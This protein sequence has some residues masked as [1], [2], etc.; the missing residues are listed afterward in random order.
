MNINEAT[1]TDLKVIEELKRLGWKPGDTLLYQPEYTLTPEQ[2]K[3]FGVKKIRPDIVLC[4][5]QGNP[6]AVIENKL[7]DEKKALTKLRTLYYHVL[8]PRFLYACSKERI[9]FSDTTWKGL[10]SGTFKRVQTFMTLDEMLIKIE[11]DKRKKLTEKIEID[12]TI[13]GGYDPAAGK[14]RYYQL[15]CVNTLIEKYKQ[16]KQKMLVHMATGLGKTRVAVALTKALLEYGLAKR[17]LFVVD[18]ILLAKQALDHGFS[19]ISKEYPAAWIK[20]YNY[21]QYRNYNIHIVVIDTLENIFQNIPNNFY[22]LIIVDECHRSITINRKL[23]FDH[24]VCPRI[25]LTA[26]P[27][28]AILD[29]KAKGEVSEQDLE[30]LD[31]YKLFGCE[32]GK[33]DYQFDLE[34]GIREGFLAPYKILEIKTYLT[35]LAEEKGIEFDFVLDPD[36]RQKIRLNR[37]K[38]LKLEQLERQYLSEERAK[39]IAEEIKKHVQYGEKMILFG[40]SQA[41]CLMLAKAINEVFGEKDDDVSPKYCEAIISENGNEI[42]EFLKNK[43][44]DPNQKPYIVTSVD[45]MS[46]GVDVPCVRYIGFAA[47]T[48]SVGKYTQMIGRGTRLDPKSGKFSFT[49][50]DFVGLARRMNDT[51]KGSPK[52]NIV[53]IKSTHTHH[54]RLQGSQYTLT[55][56]KK[57]RKASYFLIP[58]KDPKELIQR[59]WLN[60]GQIKIIDNIPI[61]KAREIFEQEA[62]KTE[63]PEIMQLKKKL[64]Q[65]PDYEPNEEE[66]EILEEWARNPEIFLNTEQLQK[67]YR[68]PQGNMWDFFRHAIGHRRVPTLEEQIQVI[69][70]K[71]IQI[72]DLTDEQIKTLKKL[73]KIIIKNL[74]K[75]ER[76]DYSEIFS[77]PI[78]S[79]II[80]TKQELEEQFGSNISYILQEIEESFHSL[81]VSRES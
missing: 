3:E 51:G 61:E 81:K 32:S 35:K 58:N 14:E 69:F 64:S 56:E 41:H 67:I 70:D 79:Q 11:Q 62:Q 13:V 47:L 15:E 6:L 48:K 50:L 78:Y 45:I 4:D 23:I 65:N 49:V 44:R 77:N 1:T 37:P 59:V 25:G 80:G 22:D 71:Y 34:R 73:K 16:G 53:K 27:K 31:T 54:L 29:K 30:I 5:M 42:N 72:S 38:R 39:R 46:T 9:L 36:E 43:F 24:F 7:E 33:P 75:H 28:K 60:N 2:Q 20:S 55:K 63:R 17:V 57:K 68:Y 10:D 40:V 76:V 21:K 26:T 12:K 74:I 19:L 52:E 66:M 18:R 8:K